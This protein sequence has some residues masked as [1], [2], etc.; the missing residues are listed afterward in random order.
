[1][2]TPSA[3]PDPV[4]QIPFPALT[5]AHDPC[6]QPCQPARHAG[7]SAASGTRMA[8]PVP[9][10]HKNPMPERPCQFASPGGGGRHSNTAGSCLGAGWDRNPLPPHFSSSIQNAR[11]P[12][13]HSPQNEHFPRS[14]FQP[15][16][17]LRAPCPPNSGTHQAGILAN[18][19]LLASHL[20]IFFPRVPQLWAPMGGQ[21]KD[22]KHAHLPQQVLTLRTP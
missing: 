15:S 17:R 5:A 7:D 12:P 4:L 11:L 22:P 19:V 6:P 16:P 21:A 2:A 3:K 14:R 13:L 20:F 1:M 18:L 10:P 9:A 8:P